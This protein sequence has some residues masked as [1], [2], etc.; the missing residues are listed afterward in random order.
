[1]TNT[2]KNPRL[3]AELRWVAQ[4]FNSLQNE[5]ATTEQ[6]LR[7]AQN[8]LTIGE[9]ALRHAH[10]LPEFLDIPVRLDT[11]ET[12]NLTEGQRMLLRWHRDNNAL[13]RV[14][15]VREVDGLEGKHYVELGPFPEDW[16]RHKGLIISS[17]HDFVTGAR[18]IREEREERE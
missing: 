12:K 16:I 1:M 7:I 10:E 8:Q 17:I 5:K 2:E 18:E 3:Q 13:T 6:Q 9:Y 11:G 4:R 15:E 14:L